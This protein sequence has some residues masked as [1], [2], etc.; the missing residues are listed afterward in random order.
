[1]PSRAVLGALAALACSAPGPRDV[2]VG[3][4]DCARCHMTVMDPRFAAEA[5]TRTGKV[6]VFDD[7]A[8]LAGFLVAG[9]V[10]E[11]EVHSLWAADYL[12]AG[13]WLDVGEAVF[14][15][16]DGL[17]SPMAG[18]VVA[19]RPGPAAD[20]L[21]DALGGEFLDWEA[22][23]A[24]LAAGSH[25][26]G[27]AAPSPRATADPRPGDLVVGAGVGT[28]AEAVRRAPPGGR[29][30]VPAGTWREPTI[31]VDRPLEIVGQPG[32]V[33]DGGGHHGLLLVTA[34]DV[35]VRGLTLRNTGLTFV[36]DRAALKVTRGRRCV[37][38]D[39]V[40][41]G[42]MF[43]LYISE[44]PGCTVRRNRIVGTGARESQ[45]GNAIHLWYSP[46]AVV[47]DNRVSRHRDGIYLEFSERGVVR[48]N[49]STG[50]RR[51]GLHFMF[52]HDAR[53]EGNEFTA[54]GAGVAVMYSRGVTMH[55]NTFARSRGPASYGL[56]LKD[57]TDGSITG[58]RFEANTVGLWSEGATRLEIRGNAFRSNGWAIRLMANTEACRFE[59]NTFE[60]NTFDVATNGRQ[61]SSTF[62]G[63]WW[64]TYR[65][66]D[67]DR[68]GT[69]DI[70]FQPVRLF[71][72]LVERYPPALV[73]NR[74]LFV[75]L[76][77]AA[78]RVLPVLAP[79]ALADRSPLMRS[80]A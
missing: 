70:P 72:Y 44:S 29:V 30:V 26:H 1:M 2:A 71:A 41:E 74:S 7:L 77:D 48:R 33:L 6:F 36:E 69:G 12:G 52:S 18:N 10:P 75:E 40:V 57:I 73:V 16:S 46:D 13:G 47:E 27:A 4:E 63:N 53:Y 8:C 49:A 34:D 61:H 59:A 66:Y 56:L 28:I 38:E 23:R 5:V 9:D 24:R 22:A 39:L 21:R 60:A 11:G 54:N 50:N 20:S 79:E 67:L 3:A 68:D 51:Y 55:D 15:A 42:A 32:A 17:R 14:L 35:T 19:V 65:G 78:E 58:N 64:D 37:L 80:P 62:A 25:G 76:L 43:A 31:T 45:S